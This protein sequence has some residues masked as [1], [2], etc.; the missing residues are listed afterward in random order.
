MVSPPTSPLHLFRS[1]LRECTYLPDRR[2]R[3]YMHNYVLWSYRTYLPKPKAWRKPIEFKRQVKLLHRGR[4]WLSML[5]RAN[6][7]Y[8]KPL[9]K[10]LM[11]TYGRIGKRR[12]ELM[13]KAMAPE[14]PQTHEEVAAFSAPKLYVKEWKPP[15]RVD[16]LMR[17]QAKYQSYLNKTSTK[18]K[19]KVKIPVENSWGKPMPQSRVRNMTHDWYVEQVDHLLPPLPEPEWEELRALAT[20]DIIWHR[21][22]KRKTRTQSDSALDSDALTENTL[23]EGPN[24]GHTFRDYINGRPHEI[25]PRLMRRLWTMVFRHV[26]MLSWNEN[27]E[28]WTVEW[29]NAEK[30]PQLIAAPSRTRDALL[31]SSYEKP[32]KS[33]A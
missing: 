4:K 21:P 5:Q 11:L 19:T 2:A 18:V 28:K 29:G 24:K 13:Q 33:P 9:E 12:R 16:A 3:S 6:E 14:P 27:R 15:A 20:G 22:A 32:S 26:P 17:S 1:L 10:V 7:G 25:T 30:S 23:L 31:F 8:P